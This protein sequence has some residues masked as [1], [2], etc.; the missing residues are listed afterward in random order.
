M[1]RVGSPPVWESITRILR[2]PSVLMN[3]P[4]YM[5]VFVDKTENDCLFSNL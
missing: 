5:P 1:S 3:S 4:N 2:Y